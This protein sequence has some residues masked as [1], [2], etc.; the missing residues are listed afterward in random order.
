MQ[1]LKYDTFF[2]YQIC[3]GTFEYL[4]KGFELLHPHFDPLHVFIFFYLPRF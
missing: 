4:L 3:E 2:L 1:A